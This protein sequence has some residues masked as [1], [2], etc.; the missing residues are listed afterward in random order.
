MP[1]NWDLF[2]SERHNTPHTPQRPC[3]GICIYAVAAKIHSTL[4][5]KFGS[6]P[7]NVDNILAAVQLRTFFSIGRFSKGNGVPGGANVGGRKYV[8]P[9]F[10]NLLKILPR[11]WLPVGAKFPFISSLSGSYADFL[12]PH[13]LLTSICFLQ[14]HLGNCSLWY[15]RIFSLHLW[16][17]IPFIS[18][19]KYNHY[20]LLLL[21]QWISN[22][23]SL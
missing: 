20:P 7:E 21:F 16:P 11:P 19:T 12:L 13:F 3:H 17:F 5:S 10:P 1:W 8:R 4:W 23:H 2:R 15:K 22:L 6:I 9:P 18:M 14:R